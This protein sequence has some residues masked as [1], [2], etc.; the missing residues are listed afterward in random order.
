MAEVGARTAL[1]LNHLAT[2]IYG[3][4]LIAEGALKA[5]RSVVSKDLMPGWLPNIPP[6]ASSP[7]PQIQESISPYCPLTAIRD[8]HQRPVPPWR[9]LV[10]IR[11]CETNFP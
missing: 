9:G 3:G 2:S 7:G 11:F 6:A 4:S 5:A 8:L 1:R 10:L